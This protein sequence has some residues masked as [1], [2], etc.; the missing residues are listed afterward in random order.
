MA[1]A[2]PAP[3][4]E[5]IKR[6]LQQGRYAPVY[7]LHGAEG[8]YTDAL[9][10]EFERIVPEEDKPFC[11]YIFY[12]PETEPGMII[13]QCRQVSMMG[14][15]NVVIV[16]ECQSARAD[17]I[18]RLRSYLADPNP[19]TVLV[20]AFRGSEIKGAEFK[21]ALKKCGD[22][23][24]FE[25]KKVYENNIPA[26]VAE[27]LKTKGLSADSKATEML[28][29]F[30][31]TDL[32]RLYNELDKLAAILPP[33]AAITPEVVERNIGV[34]RDFN[35]FELVDAI[36]VKDAVKVFR[37]AEYFRANQKNNP[38]VMVTAALFSYFQD[39]MVAWYT[40][41]RTDREIQEA[42]K[43]KSSFQVRRFRSGLQNYTPFAVVE[44]ISAIRSFDVSSKGVDSRQDPY[45]LL[46][47]LLYHILTADGSIAKR[48]L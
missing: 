47:D 12:A 10:R 29:D 48:N 13:D 20:L 39:L 11:Q 17:Q 42:L 3:T 15:R 45:D 14:D 40:P 16:K 36:A 18:D 21:K 26:L 32:S 6:Q 34:S 38:L 5:S 35:S 31:G 27:Y 43:L 37:I 19:S 44:I 22:A 24:V 4:F 46:R 9:I 33:H 25:S 41:G 28:R 30:I 2:A 8:Y 1:T 23:V 7:V